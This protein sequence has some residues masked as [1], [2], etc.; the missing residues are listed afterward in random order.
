MNSQLQDDVF[1]V[2]FRGNG[3]TTASRAEDFALLRCAELTIKNN[4]K[5]F[6]ILDKQNQVLT[7][8]YTSPVTSNTTGS[9]N[10]YSTGN[11][12][13][14]S[15]SGFTTYSGGD[16]TVINK[17]LVAVTIQCF[18]EKPNTNGMVYDAEQ[19]I[20]N[21][22]GSYGL[23]RKSSLKLSTGKNIYIR[24]EKYGGM[25]VRQ[26]YIYLADNNEFHKTA[27]MNPAKVFEGYTKTKEYYNL[28]GE[29]ADKASQLRGDIISDIDKAVSD[30]ATKNKIRAVYKALEGDEKYVEEKDISD[31]IISI[32]NSK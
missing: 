7:S 17:P 4:F 9:I 15:Y 24:D 32:L 8:I 23:A 16:T 26:N 28:I 11:F 14:G 20:N 18:R 19:V 21:L 29:N 10:M 2:N 1:R 12:T 3:Y 6:V 5:Y 31:E 25:M 22:I 13:N 27:K 30:Y